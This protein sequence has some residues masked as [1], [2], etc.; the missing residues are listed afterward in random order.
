MRIVAGACVVGYCVVWLLAKRFRMRGG[1][2]ILPMVIGIV[3]VLFTGN[4]VRWAAF[5]GQLA[6]AAQPG[7]GGARASFACERVLRGAWAS[8]GRVGHVWFGPDGRPAGDAFL[9]MDTCSRIKAWRSDPAGASVEQIV[10]VHTVTHES[11]HLA[12]IRDEAAAEC[13][14]VQRDTTT[15]TRLGATRAEAVKQVGEYLAL[16]YPRLPDAYR[17]DQCVSGGTLDQTPGDGT[18]P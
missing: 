9:S 12:G 1:W 5:E 13:S 18:W 14:A 3:A 10:A 6:G 2:K 4:E 11:A 15:M 16:V 7:M 17:S 8:Q